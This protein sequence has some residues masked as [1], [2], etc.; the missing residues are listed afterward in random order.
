[1]RTFSLP[2][3]L[4]YCTSAREVNG[5]SQGGGWIGC[6]CRAVD[7][8]KVPLVRARSAP[9]CLA[10]GLRDQLVSSH[11]ALTQVPLCALH[12]PFDHVCGSILL[13]RRLVERHMIGSHLLDCLWRPVVSSMSVAV[14]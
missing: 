11:L 9:S 10:I 3:D 13:L 14:M 8:K 7:M 4:S 6:Q 5:R 12:S 1:M 2:L